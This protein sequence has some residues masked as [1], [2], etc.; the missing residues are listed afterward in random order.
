MNKII[1]KGRLTK[2]PIASNT[3]TDKVLCRFTI[4]VNNRFKKGDATFIDCVAWEKI[5]DFILKYFNKGSEII[6]VG[7]LE[8]NNYTDKDGIDVKRLIVTV[9]EPY[10]C[11]SKQEKP[12]AK[13]PN[14]QYQK[15][16]EGTESVEDDFF[17]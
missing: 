12:E 9:E 4:A 14:T 15:K 17:L 2:D 5:A 16:P 3:K 8:S 13:Q 6:I 11:G 10:F 7:R 1:L